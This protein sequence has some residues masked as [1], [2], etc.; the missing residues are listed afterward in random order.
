M[1]VQ[2]CLESLQE[3]L[4]MCKTKSGPALPPGLLQGVAEMGKLTVEG[5]PNVTF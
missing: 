4:H 1:S 5:Q 2:H 3:N